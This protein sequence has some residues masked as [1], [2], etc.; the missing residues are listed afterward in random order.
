MRNHDPFLLLDEFTLNSKGGFP[1]HPHRGFEAVTYMLS[2]QMQ[3]EDFTGKEGTVGPGD[4]QW[5][6][7]G[8]GVMHCEMPVK[9]PNSSGSNDEPTIHGLQLWVNLS[10]KDKMCEPG[11][12]GLRDH[13]IPRVKATEGVEVK[14]IAG[15]AHGAKSKIFTRTPIMY[16]D[17]KM[18]SNS[19]VE[20]AIPQEF[21]GFVYMLAGKAYFGDGV[22]VSSSAEEEKFDDKTSHVK[23]NEATSK[24]FEGLPYHALILSRDDDSDTLKIQTKDQDARFVVLAG[25]PLKEPVVQGGGGLFV[26][27]TKEEVEQATEDVRQFKN[28]FERA[29]E[30][31]SKISPK[32]Y[33]LK[34]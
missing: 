28:G 9:D 16:L 5:M 20:V 34:F 23:I 32:G 6:T 29:K 26:M 12:Q 17:Y 33:R 30:W 2:G 22:V 19:S 14:V 21:E 13:Q 31:R 24:P 4:L 18:K 10:Q 8:K 11:Y 1:D 3:H 7:A 27:N 25:R 15:E